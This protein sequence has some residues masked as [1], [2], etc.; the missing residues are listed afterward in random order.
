MPHPAVRRT[1]IVVVRRSLPPLLGRSAAHGMR[2]PRVAAA[3]RGFHR[4]TVSHTD[5]TA[6]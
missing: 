2:S 4:Q 1:S 5:V 6:L 3:L